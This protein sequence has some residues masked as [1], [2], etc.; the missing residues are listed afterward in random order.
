MVLSQEIL[1]S[2]SFVPVWIEIVSALRVAA[3]EGGDRT[4]WRKV[5]V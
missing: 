4:D 1:V 3:A 2:R 5:L